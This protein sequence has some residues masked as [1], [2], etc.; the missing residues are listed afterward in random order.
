MDLYHLCNRGV[1]KRTIFLDDQ[2]H[3]RFVHDLF[4][5]NDQQSVSS[6]FYYFSKSSDIG[7]PNIKSRVRESR[8]L[9][10]HIHCFCLMPNHYHM[11]V[12]PLVDDAIPRF[13]KKLNMGYAKYFNEKY[14]RVGALFQGKYRSV[15]VERD[16]HFLHLP[17][18][19]HFNP[20][21][22]VAPEWRHRQIQNAKKALAFLERYRW[23][24]HRDFL[25]EKNFPSITQRDFL[26]D[27]FGGSETYRA[28]IN[29]AIATLEY[30][31]IRSLTF[32]DDN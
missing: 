3:F 23:S 29:E 2:D 25:G 11:L 10:V 22:I 21:D 1:D 5:F 13:M 27:F 9:L 19:I 26:L 16:A 28:S 20:L 31:S 4:E 30:D 12:S 8:K 18:Y 7:C 14:K 32:D 15:L 6:N 24:S 17:Y